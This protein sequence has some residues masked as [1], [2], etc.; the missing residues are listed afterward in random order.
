[1]ITRTL[2]AIIKEKLYKG[3]IIVLLGAR[4]VGK[5]TL[6]EQLKE[7][8]F[9]EMSVVSFNCDEP[10]DRALLTDANSADLS[11]VVKSSRIVLIDEAQRVQNIGLTLKLLA[12]K[13]QD[14][15]VLVSGSSSLELANKINEPLTGRKFE[16]LM[17]PIS[18]EELIN[19]NG[20]L[21]T[22]RLL[23]NRLIYGSYPDILFQKTDTKELLFELT[24][25]YLFKDIYTL[26]ELRKP[27]VLE[28]LLVA[29]ALQIGSEVSYNE[30]SQTVQTDVKTVERY[31]NLLEKCFI[32]FKLSGLNNNLRNELK[33][34]KKIF[35]YD[36]GIRN[37]LLQNFLPLNL[38]NDVG[39]LWENFFIS[40]RLKFNNYHNRFTKMYFWRTQQ[41]Q[42]IDLVED[43]E[44]KIIAY[45]MK[46]NE[47][48]KTS[49]PNNFVESYKPL[50]TNIIT[51][52]NYMG[53]LVN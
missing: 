4:Q 20:M 27:E 14:I 36:N 10:N 18:T 17:L 19:A 3:K 46:W 29:L 48:R 1:M 30:L 31:I 43:S 44:G 35:F 47:N 33:K 23:E 12:D 22:Q 16:Y 2:Q 15:Q 49:F 40:E 37:A 52:K 42:E 26:Q 34:S 41:Q 28:K 45:E 51:P 24:N 32:V 38:R 5:S 8:E 9:A 7:S 11:A 39:A 53:F 25:S 50:Q 13:F 6:F 21:E